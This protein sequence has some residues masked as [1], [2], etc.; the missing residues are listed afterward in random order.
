M[1]LNKYNG[2]CIH[3]ITPSLPH[4]SKINGANERNGL[5][6]APVNGICAVTMMIKNKLI[7]ND[8]IKLQNSTE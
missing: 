1:V 5:H 2:Y 3:P 8:T 7:S 4:D 6:E